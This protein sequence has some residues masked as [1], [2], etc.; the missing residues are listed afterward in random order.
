MDSRTITITLPLPDRKLSPNARCHWRVKAKCVKNSRIDS[1]M[2]TM[3]A[4]REFKLCIAFRKATVQARFYVKDAWRKRDG[5]NLNA[6]LKSVL[7]GLADAGLLL[8]DR[9]ITLLPPEVLEG[10]DQ[11]LELVVTE[12][13]YG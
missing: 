4:M 10:A 3:A 8:N 13:S 12:T 9:D 6:S 2:A 7:D 5:D 1:G 11:R